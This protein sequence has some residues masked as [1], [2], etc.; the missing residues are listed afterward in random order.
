MSSPGSPVNDAYVVVLQAGG[1]LGI[2]LESNPTSGRQRI[3]KIVKGGAADRS[4]Q[5]H[6]GD[7]VI[8]VNGVSLR[9]KTHIEAVDV[10]RA[11]ITQGQRNV[12][13]RMVPNNSP[14]GLAGATAAVAAARRKEVVAAAA[15]RTTP[16]KKTNSRQK[17]PYSP[18]VHPP[19]Q[20]AADH[21]SDDADAEAWMNGGMNAAQDPPHQTAQC[22]GFRQQRLCCARLLLDPRV[23][24][25]TPENV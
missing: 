14:T 9:D 5:I 13:F 6:V 21:D 23:L 24:G 25:L 11:A 19:W 20:G 12:S 3:G 10:I 15:G 7:D 4:G 2:E 17:A 22:S 16:K 8:A 18:P 1:P